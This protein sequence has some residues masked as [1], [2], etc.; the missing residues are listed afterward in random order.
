MERKEKKLTLVVIIKNDGPG[1]EIINMI[2]N[3]ELISLV[4]L[5]L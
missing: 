1:S 4:S 2:A 5:Y 3:M